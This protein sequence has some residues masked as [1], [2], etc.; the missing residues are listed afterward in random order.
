MSLEY[1]WLMRGCMRFQNILRCA[2][3]S[4]NP[5]SI[6]NN[7]AKSFFDKFSHFHPFLTHQSNEVHS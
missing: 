3:F 6:F 2:V 7:T 1:P 5:T 4:L